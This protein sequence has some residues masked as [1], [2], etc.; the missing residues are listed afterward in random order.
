MRLP[1]V[2]HF[3][4]DLATCVL[5]QPWAGV[6]D[7]HVGPWSCIRPCPRLWLGPLLI[8][9]VWITE[10]AACVFSVCSGG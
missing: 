9:G 2:R 5:L 4:R 7:S 8:V 3:R 1:L 6:G 10:I